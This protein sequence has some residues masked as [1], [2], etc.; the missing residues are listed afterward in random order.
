M[1]FRAVFYFI[2]FLLINGCSKNDNPVQ[3][4]NDVVLKDQI[5]GLWKYWNQN[6]IE[7]KSDN[8]FTDTI[9]TIYDTTSIN[10]LVLIVKGDYNIQD[11]I[12][13]FSNIKVE[14]GDSASMPIGVVGVGK[15]YTPFKVQVSE[16]ELIVNQMEILYKTSGSLNDIFGIWK[17]EHL[18]AIVE[19]RSQN[20]VTTQ[21]TI[22]K[23]FQ[24]FQDSTLHFVQTNSF[25]SPWNTFDQ[26]DSYVYNSQQL[27]M[28]G[29]FNAKATINNS[30]MYVT[31]DLPAK[32]FIRI[33]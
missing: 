30:I 32:V 25:D 10:H 22:F 24:F 13:Y 18:K 23:T 2:V 3:S 9:W 33:N 17:T 7:F 15:D 14:Y 31:Y 21:G 26:T 11:S 16:H 6:S 5:T 27:N 29:Q 19:R 28:V 12:L 4:N 8:T 20:F 1:V